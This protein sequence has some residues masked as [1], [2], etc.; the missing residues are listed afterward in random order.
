MKKYCWKAYGFQRE[1]TLINSTFTDG[2]STIAKE[3]AVNVVFGET[4]SLALKKR[5]CRSSRNLH[6]T[7]LF[8]N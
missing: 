7:L 8:Q 6:L 3:A 2:S 4:I 1:F 5:F